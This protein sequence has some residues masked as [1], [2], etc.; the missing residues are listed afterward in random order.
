MKRT[1]P[2]FVLMI[3]F[4]LPL[5]SQF[6]EETP[7]SMFYDAESWYTDEEEYEEAAYLYR[8]ILREEPDNA[9]V[10]YLLGMCYLNIRGSEFEAIPWFREAT[11]DITLKYKPVRYSVKEAPHHTWY[12]LADAY[13]RTNQLD[14]ALVALEQFSSLRNFEKHY[15]LSMTEDFTEQV[16]RAKIIRDSELNLRALYFKEPINT[17][18]DDYSGVISADGK[19]MVWA[20]SKT[21]YEAVYMSTRKEND[22][23]V[24]VE[25]STQIVSEGNLFPT[26]LSAD[27][28]TMLLVMR[29]TRGD[30]DIWYSNYDGMF[31]SPAQPLHGEINSGSNESHASFSP[32]GRRI[33]FTSDRRGGEG[34]T[35]IW[36]SDRQADGQWG[37]PVN[38]GENINTEEDETSAYVAPS[39]GRFIFASKGHFNMGGFDIF[40][41]ERQA[42]G[43]WGTPTNMGYPVNTTSDDTYYVPLNEGLSGLY[44]RFTNEAI[45]RTDLWYVQVEGED[46][47]IPDGL[48]LAL[49]TREGLANKD[50]AIILVDQDTGEEIE[51]LY[52]AANDSF[53]ALSAQGRDFRVV[54]YKQD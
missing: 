1:I 36:Y 37:D 12:Y 6:E 31:W 11:E 41:C 8:R 20:S 27:G 28:T 16:E 17:P 5:L 30:E 7:E 25:I 34:G 23:T 51:V 10:K 24:P 13:R 43:T 45:G 54:S 39:E 42:D 21:F 4:Q 3:L 52:D 19:M 22:W 33:Y 49:D 44:S 50:F 14:S 47:V 2:A 18:Q 53:R 29:P 46:G 38:M 15:N 40:R 48:V 35:D 9:N 26:G 32:D